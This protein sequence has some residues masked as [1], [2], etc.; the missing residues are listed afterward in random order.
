VHGEPKTWFTVLSS[1]ANVTKV[2]TPY[3]LMA[4]LCAEAI[5]CEIPHVATK[6][7]YYALLKAHLTLPDKRPDSKNNRDDGVAGN[8]RVKRRRAAKPKPEK[9]LKP[10]PVKEMRK[11]KRVEGPVGVAEE[12]EPDPKLDLKPHP[13]TARAHGE[14]GEHEWQWQRQ[15][16]RQS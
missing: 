15:Q 9:T 10:T 6:A 13:N 5:K 4:L 8:S 14:D 16:R 12:P 7:V 3:Y 1:T 11:G 2:S